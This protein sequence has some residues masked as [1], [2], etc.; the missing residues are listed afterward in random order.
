M[1]LAFEEI[2]KNSFVVTIDS[3][4]YNAFKNSFL[5]ANFPEELL[6]KKFIGYEL[7]DGFLTSEFKAVFDLQYTKVRG[8][9]EQER[10]KFWRLCNNASHFAIVQH[11]MLLDLPFVTIFEDD[12]VP[13]ENCIEKLNAYCS[14]VPDDTDV[15]RLGYYFPI[16]KLFNG[17]C[18]VYKWPEPEEN[19][20]IVSCFH[21]SHAYIVFKKYYQRFLESNKYQPRCD[22][23]RINPSQDKVVYALREPLFEQIN[24][25]DAPVIHA[26]R[27]KDGMLKLPPVH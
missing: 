16:K 22:K 18:K 1:T 3:K 24:I 27:L 6:P 13:V 8:Y 2:M 17:R 25:L 19:G 26:Y 20:F 12:A 15:L 21:G 5:S 10:K 7:V 14:N 4:R 9:F 23:D 11:A